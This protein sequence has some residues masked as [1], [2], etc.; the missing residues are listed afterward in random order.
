MARSVVLLD[1]DDDDIF[2]L[3]DC[4]LRVDKNLQIT[5]FNDSE[6]ALDKLLT[7]KVGIPDYIFIDLNMPKI[8]GPQCLEI[9]RGHK[10]FETSTIVM[11]STTMSDEDSSRHVRNGASV[12]V[13]KP[14][15]IEDYCTLLNSII[16]VN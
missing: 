16:A 4:L 8:M 5:A 7:G 14:S 11:I 3:T 10:A 9:I 2:T 15:N 6:D 1:D 12:A 13:K